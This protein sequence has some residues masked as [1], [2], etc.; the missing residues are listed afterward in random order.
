VI[1][2]PNIWGK[3]ICL[4]CLTFTRV[5]H[6]IVLATL[7]AGLESERNDEGKLEQGKVKR[8]EVV[9]DKTRI[10]IGTLNGFPPN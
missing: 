8:G 3:Q 9:I 7:V 10:R 6:D 5:D 2:F 1:L 4:C